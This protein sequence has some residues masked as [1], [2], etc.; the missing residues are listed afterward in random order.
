MRAEPG[1]MAR[2]LKSGCLPGAVLPWQTPEADVYAVVPQRL[3]LATRVRLL[4]TSSPTNLP[5]FE[6]R[7]LEALIGSIGHVLQGVGHSAGQPGAALVAH[8]REHQTPAITVQAA[9]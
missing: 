5:S 7:L 1:D 6:A 4:P 9:R 3:Q 2:H 8:R